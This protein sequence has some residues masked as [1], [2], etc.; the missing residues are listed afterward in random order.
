MTEKATFLL[1]DKFLFTPIR[2][3]IVEMFNASI[4]LLL[5]KF[6]GKSYGLRGKYPIKKMEN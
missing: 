3:L 1:M 6:S 2:L 4:S 5:D